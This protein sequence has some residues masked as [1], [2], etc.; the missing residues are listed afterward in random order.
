MLCL[1]GVTIGGAQ[2]LSSQAT[3]PQV[4]YDLFSS[5]VAVTYSKM[6]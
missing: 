1:Y 3:I 2:G 6:N 5:F 4:Y